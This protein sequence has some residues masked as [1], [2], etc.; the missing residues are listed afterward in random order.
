M[1]QQVTEEIATDTR[2]L[3]WLSSQ[4]RRQN[5]LVQHSSGRFTLRPQLLASCARP[6]RL[7]QLPGPLCLPQ[8]GSG[9]LVLDNVAAL[10]LNQQLSLFDWLGR[11]SGDVRVI[12]VTSEPLRPLVEAGAFLEGLFHRLSSV[13]LDLTSKSWRR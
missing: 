8:D 13:Q 7:C 2:L 6:V 5:F 4:Q 9:T 3:M 10:S 11:C 12:S 1:L